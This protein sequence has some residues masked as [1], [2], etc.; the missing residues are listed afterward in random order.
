MNESDSA[1]REMSTDLP[2]AVSAG[3]LPRRTLALEGLRTNAVKSYRL[4]M[5]Y[6]VN[7]SGP[8]LAI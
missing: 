3:Q 6:I 5:G 1:E 4:L 8:Q 7:M 2:R